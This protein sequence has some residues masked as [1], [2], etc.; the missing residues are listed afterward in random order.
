MVRK[1]KSSYQPFLHP[2][3]K[4]PGV[5]IRNE[6]K[7]NAIVLNLESQFQGNNIVDYDTEREINDTVKRFLREDIPP[8]LENPV[9]NDDI[10]QEIKKFPNKKAPGVSGITNEA[11]KNLPISYISVGPTEKP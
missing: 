10:I 8:I 9:S 5:C 1:F 2:Y 3:S 4:H 6:E 7:A 11:F